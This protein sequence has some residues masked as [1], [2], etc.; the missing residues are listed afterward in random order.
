[1][2]YIQVLNIIGLT[3][4]WL[5]YKNYLLLT[6]SKCII[7]G[8]IYDP[9]VLYDSRCRIWSLKVSQNVLILSFLD[10][11]IKHRGCSL[12]EFRLHKRRAARATLSKEYIYEKV[13]YFLAWD[14]AAQNAFSW[15]HPLQA[16][17]GSVAVT[18]KNLYSHE[19]KAKIKFEEF[20]W[21]S[22]TLF[23][24]RKAPSKHWYFIFCNCSKTRRSKNVFL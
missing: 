2:R 15:Y 12:S 5:V 9:L 16:E 11:S 4:L 23:E 3:R 19:R 21:S 10:M 22:R 8:T 20:F 13:C 14:V 24:Y 7:S 1:M 17:L 6:V 18:M